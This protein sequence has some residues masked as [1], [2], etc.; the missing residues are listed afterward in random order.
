MS[1]YSQYL[2]HPRS[3]GA[4]LHYL[5]ELGVPL[6]I[7]EILILNEG[8]LDLNGKRFATYTWNEQDVP[9]FTF[10]GEGADYYNALYQRRGVA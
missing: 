7:V 9:H 1:S 2:K 6:R 5:Q 3:A 10:V 4:V 8:A